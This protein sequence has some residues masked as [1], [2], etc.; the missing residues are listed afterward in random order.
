AFT[1]AASPLDGETIKLWAAHV[2]AGSATEL[3]GTVLDVSG[4]GIAVAAADGVVTVT[5]L[6]RSGGKRLPVADFLRGFDVKAG[7]VFGL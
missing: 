7:Q 6:Q 1:C 4:S 3:P 2:K 5:E